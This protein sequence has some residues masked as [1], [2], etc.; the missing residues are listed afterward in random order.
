MSYRNLSMIASPACTPTNR[1]L[2]STATRRLRAWYVDEHG[3]DGGDEI[4]FCCCTVS[5]SSV[6][7]NPAAVLVI[8]RLSFP[9]EVRLAFLKSFGLTVDRAA[10]GALATPPPPPPPA[11][12]ECVTATIL[13]TWIGSVFRVHGVS[14][15]YPYPQTVQ[16][17]HCRQALLNSLV[18]GER[19]AK[20]SSNGEKHQYAKVPAGIP[21]IPRSRG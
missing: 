5:M 21:T 1:V 15:V 16:R 19:T 9:Q 4:T 14:N 11:S 6:R 17:Q 3:R 7:F 12:G 13:S 18:D 8:P 20:H 10:H 2:G